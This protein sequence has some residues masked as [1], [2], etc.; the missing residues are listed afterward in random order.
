MSQKRNQA[1]A[2]RPLFLGV[3][4]SMPKRIARTFSLA[5]FLV[6]VTIGPSMGASESGVVRSGQRLSLNF[7]DTTLEVV[8]QQLQRDARITVRIPSVLMDRKVTVK[9]QNMEIDPALETL[10][11][12]ASLRN[13][14]VVHEPGAQGHITVIMVED[15]K[16]VAIPPPQASAEESASEPA[17]PRGDSIGIANDPMMG[18]RWTSAKIS[19]S[20]SGA[21]P[22]E[23]IPQLPQFAAEE[24]SGPSPAQEMAIPASGLPPAMA[25]LPPE[26]GP[27][28]P[29][30]PEGS[31]LTPQMRAAMAFPPAS[32]Q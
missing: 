3:I 18:A 24:A 14:A 11:K 1:G 27:K 4:K 20:D 16:G 19:D 5:I 2:E 15:G 21:P 17:Q 23:T 10:F 6:L 26:P 22:Q 31:P 8:L 13:F 29:G 12:S 9:L 32:K 25:N 28:Y 30:G 7:H